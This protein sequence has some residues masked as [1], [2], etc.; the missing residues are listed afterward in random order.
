MSIV[1]SAAQMG[2]LDRQTTQRFGL[3][4]R[5]LMEVAGRAVAQAVNQLLPL[6][7]A[8]TVACG[9]G[10]NG[11]DG[12]VA[13]R[14]LAAAGHTVEVCVFAARER[15]QGAALD[16][17]LALELG[18]NVKLTLG[19]GP[20]T[21][22]A[23]GEAPATV[24]VDAL[25]GI[26]LTSS[27]R[28]ILADAIALI[29]QRRI[30]EACHVVSVDIPSGLHTDTGQI[31]GGAVRADVTVTFGCA[32]LAHHLHPGRRLTGELT[33]ADIGLAPAL[34]KEQR[35]P[36][37]TR[38][39]LSHDGPTLV[40][41]RAA[42]CHK[43]TFGHLMVVA[44]SAATPGAALLCL[45]AALRSG[46][47][48]VSW[49]A[50]APTCANSGG[51]PPE[52]MLRRREGSAADSAASML[53]GAT[54]LAVGPG[55]GNTAATAELLAALLRQSSVPVCLDA[56]GLYA[57]SENPELWALVG[58]RTVLT[59]HPKEMARLLG[60]QASVASVQA[61]RLGAARKLASERQ[62]IVVLKGA[63]TVL[64][65]AQGDSAVVPAGSP[66][67]ATGGTGDVLCGIIGGLLAQ[68][69]EPWL[70]A[71]AGTLLH[72]CAGEAAAHRL[73]EAAVLASDVIT[74]LSE[75]WQRW[76]R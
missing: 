16:A 40:A 31:M 51:A 60:G 66:A 69:L 49:A 34:F 13:A 21:L 76:K 67:L 2:E 24:L 75:V 72:G 61:D 6:P 52:V 42:D 53:A 70:A 26:G 43:G 55:L 36:A 28:G 8:V 27:V 14:A 5:L 58:A 48:L 57:L 38:L 22:S 45:G 29:N 37:W 11:G 10:N 4:G 20:A 23:L 41:K 9:P 44:G 64:A 33:T 30:H 7:A 73:G 25:L 3:P 17:L 71:Q 62:C 54:A 65:N 56:D 32:K 18:G 50:D 39:L 59:P 1:V 12:L 63:G 47:G 46:A 68:R 15:L 35:A 74:A 19:D